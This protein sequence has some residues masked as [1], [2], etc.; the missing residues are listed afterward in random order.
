V[1]ALDSAVVEVDVAQVGD[2]V[3]GDL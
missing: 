1:Q 2:V 3:S